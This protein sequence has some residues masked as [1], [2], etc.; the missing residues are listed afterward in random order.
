[1]PLESVMR[2]SQLL[3]FLE[4]RPSDKISFVDRL[5]LMA[6]DVGISF[7]LVLTSFFMLQRYRFPGKMVAWHP[8]KL[9]YE[10]AASTILRGI[11]HTA[12]T[13]QFVGPYRRA[14]IT[15]GI[16]TFAA[17]NIWMWAT[18]LHYLYKEANEQVS[19][20]D[21]M[22]V[23]DIALGAGLVNYL[24]SQLVNLWVLLASVYFYEPVCRHQV[25]RCLYIMDDHGL[26][27]VEKLVLAAGNPWKVVSGPSPLGGT[28]ATSSVPTRPTTKISGSDWGPM[29]TSWRPLVVGLANTRERCLSLIVWF[30]DNF[31]GVEDQLPVLP[32]KLRDADK[33][34][35]AGIFQDASSVVEEDSSTE[36]HYTDE[37]D[38]AEDD[39]YV[40]PDCTSSL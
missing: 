14:V 20:G 18:F 5:L 24:L 2:R 9:I 34:D 38:D 32:R 4:V 15:L 37:E 36:T 10:I 19:L 3:S 23:L 11:F 1:M 22:R 33:F 8:Y 28:R 12:A 7:T 21:V 29:F 13:S 39:F 25:R 40:N 16:L 30:S 35:F 17:I 26:E 27:R 6:N 31:L